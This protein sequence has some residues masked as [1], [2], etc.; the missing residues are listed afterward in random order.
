MT[1]YFSA[2]TPQFL[3]VG[4]GVICIPS[5]TLVTLCV[6]GGEL[7]VAVHLKCTSGA[8]TISETT[9]VSVLFEEISF[10]ALHSTAQKNQNHS[11]RAGR[12]P[13]NWKTLY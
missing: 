8:L 7:N 4:L 6:L 2:L 1:S 13:C 3:F 9:A 11:E 12:N 10:S 5:P